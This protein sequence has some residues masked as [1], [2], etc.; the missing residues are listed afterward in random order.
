MA[1][2]IITL[3][4]MPE[5]P[6]VDLSALKDKVNLEI[7]EFAGEEAGKVEEEPVAFGLKALIMIFVMEESIGSTDALENK[8]SEFKEVASV[9]VTDVRRALG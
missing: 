9:N 6:D 2:V 1:K 5:S 7:K 8:I 4:M 3:K